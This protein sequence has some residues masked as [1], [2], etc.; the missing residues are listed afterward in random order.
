MEFLKMYLSRSTQGFL[1]AADLKSKRLSH[2]EF[3]PHDLSIAAGAIR[4]G[5]N[6][7]E[8]WPMV[9]AR[10]DSIS[11][12]DTDPMLTERAIFAGS[13]RQGK[14]SRRE[15]AGTPPPEY[16]LPGLPDRATSD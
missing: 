10:I 13:L 3:P 14:R 15:A 8:T 5:E 6:G 12:P 4:P 16:L 11:A 9:F 2:V 1:S 7:C